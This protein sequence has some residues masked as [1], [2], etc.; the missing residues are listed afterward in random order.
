MSI[1]WV[2]VI[3]GLVESPPQIGRNSNTLKVVAPGLI[4]RVFEEF[5]QIE[6]PLQRR[7]K[8]TGLGLPLSRRLA[9]LLLTPSLVPLAPLAS[10][11]RP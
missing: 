6:N 10:A 2:D 1:V 3:A 9:D 5:A 11:R 8:G 4:G 7:A